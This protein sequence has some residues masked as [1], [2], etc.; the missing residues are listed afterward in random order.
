MFLRTGRLPMPKDDEFIKQNM[1]MNIDKGLRIIHPKAPIKYLTGEPSG[2]LANIPMGVYSPGDY[3]TLSRREAEAYVAQADGNEKHYVWAVLPIGAFIDQD[4]TADFLVDRGGVLHHVSH[5]LVS[6]FI[7][8]KTHVKAFTLEELLIK[9]S[10]WWKVVWSADPLRDGDEILGDDGVWRPFA[11][12]VPD[13]RPPVRRRELVLDE[14][15]F[16]YL[17]VG[18]IKRVDDVRVS[19]PFVCDRVHKLVGEAGAGRPVGEGEVVMR[20]SKRTLSYVMMVEE[21]LKDEPKA[22]EMYWL[23]VWGGSPVRFGDEALH[24]DGKWR[25][26]PAGFYGVNDLRPPIRRMVKKSDLSTGQ[27]IYL[28]EGAVIAHNDVL[29][30]RA[31]GDKTLGRVDP[32]CVGKLVQA[33]E[34]IIR[35]V[36]GDGSLFEIEAPALDQW[37]ILDEFELGCEGL[38]KEGVVAGYRWRQVFDAQDAIAFRT[39]HVGQDEA[40]WRLLEDGER[41]AAG[42]QYLCVY[43]SKAGRWDFAT[44]GLKVTSKTGVLFWRR[45]VRPKE[46][47]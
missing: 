36:T 25:P 7:S 41:T 32:S 27:Y 30:I 20:Q 9:N 47:K 46:V 15:E 23:Y 26:I 14:Y 37:M 10:P 5:W 2:T 44:A 21:F 40:W 31:G 43:G 11:G 24:P 45:L 13:Y 6:M 8:G 42:D 16:F 1:D 39:K 35:Q 18:A 33:G 3:E 19:K 4:E 28:P 34:V 17:P 38:V 12:S 29:V 22:E